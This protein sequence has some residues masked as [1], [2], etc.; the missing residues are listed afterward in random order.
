[1]SD[2]LIVDEHE[3]AADHVQRREGGKSQQLVQKDPANQDAFDKSYQVKTNKQKKMLLSAR[4]H[5]HVK[6]RATNHLPT[7]PD[8]RSRNT[9]QLG[10]AASHSSIVKSLK[11]L[12]NLKVSSRRFV[13]AR[14]RSGSPSAL[15]ASPP[16][17]RA[18]AVA[19]L[20]DRAPSDTINM[21][22]GLLSKRYHDSADL[23]EVFENGHAE[24]ERE[25]ATGSPKRYPRLPTDLKVRLARKAQRATEL[26]HAQQSS[27]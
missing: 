9:E 13:D 1:M 23:R 10:G 5:Q 20:N 16:G 17:R 18:D 11:K 6:K 21:Q 27:L 14:L 4:K 25:E 15:D 8:K 12:T 3:L 22:S 2:G 26:E 24:G 7:S 19:E